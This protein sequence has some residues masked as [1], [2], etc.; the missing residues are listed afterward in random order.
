MSVQLPPDLPP[1]PDRR[2]PDRRGGELTPV[3]ERAQ[4]GRVAAASAMAI[5]G[6][7]AI[8]FLFFWMLGAIDV[9][10]AVGATVV[11]VILACIWI[12]GLVYRRREL[13][14]GTTKKAAHMDRERRG[15]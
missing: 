5:S 13:G 11:A 12:G 4:I 3:E 2:A 14:R 6:G 15:F 8:L 7:L 10:N 9:T 1:V